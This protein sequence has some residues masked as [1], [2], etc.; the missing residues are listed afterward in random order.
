MTSGIKGIADLLTGAETVVLSTH[1]KPDGDALGSMLGLG[2]VLERAGKKII[3]YL[4]DP[5]PRSYA[6]LPGVV[7]IIDS[8]VEVRRKTTGCKRVVSVALDCGDIGRLGKCWLLLDRI[9]P[10]CVIDHHQ[11]NKGF[12]DI[13]WVE[14]ECC[15][16]AEMVCDLVEFMGLGF[17]SS[18]ATCLYTGIIT[19]TGSFRYAATT[20]HTHRVAAHLVDCGASP[21]EINE[22]LHDNYSLGRLQ[23]MQMVLTT[24]ELFAGEQ[25]AVIRV[26]A[27]MMAETDTGVEDTE[28]FINLPRSIGSVQVTAFLKEGKNFVSVS[29]RSRGRCDVAKVAACFGGGGHNKASGFLVKNGG[30]ETVWARLLPIIIQQL[31]G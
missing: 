15:S 27:E 11:G 17:T 23:L 29:L 16:T 22:K 31:D 20:S 1:V 9:R 3:C 25:I 14:S 21:G 18:S 10:L 8:A 6:F 2:E 26:T 30:L 7:S 5:V 24:L 28:M 19:D 13:N 4:E 12:G